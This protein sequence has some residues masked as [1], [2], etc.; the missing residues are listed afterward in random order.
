MPLTSWIGL[1]FLTQLEACSE[2]YFIFEIGESW[3]AQGLWRLGCR[4]LRGGRRRLCRIWRLLR[5]S[6]G[7]DFRGLTAYL[8]LSA[9]RGTCRNRQ[10]IPATLS[11]ES[12]DPSLLPTIMLDH[13]TADTATQA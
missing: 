8:E 11:F 7:L 10:D 4:G 2:S 1:K 3:S 13:C 9:L 5:Y 6:H 12:L